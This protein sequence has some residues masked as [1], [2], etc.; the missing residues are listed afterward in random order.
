LLESKK[1][2]SISKIANETDFVAIYPNPFNDKILIKSNKNI[3]SLNIKDPTGKIIIS[4]T[5]NDQQIELN[6]SVIPSGIYILEIINSD[7]AL[8]QS[9]IIK[10]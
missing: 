3:I 2:E 9:K 4:K 1:E 10:Q 8:I 5:A 7:F 6:L